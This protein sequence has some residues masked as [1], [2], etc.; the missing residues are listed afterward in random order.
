M[1][2]HSINPR[3]L[4]LKDGAQYLGLT[5]WAMRERIWAGQTP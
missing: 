1:K 3:L 2:N 5:L 4:S